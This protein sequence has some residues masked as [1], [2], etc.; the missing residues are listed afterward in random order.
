MKKIVK[1]FCRRGVTA[2]GI[3]P[4]ILAVLYLIL[5]KNGAITTLTVNEV[6]IG[7][8]SLSAL[9]FIAG[10]V[11]VIYQIE[12]LPLMRAISIHGIVLYLSYLTT[13]LLNSWLAWG[14]A[15][16]LVFTV[17]FLVGYLAVWV[18]IYAVTKRNTA[19]VNAMLSQ[20]RQELK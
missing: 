7:I 3:G 11:N 20:N 9:A 2:C 19:Q 1:E 12:T 16:I 4:I 6:C 5:Q 13:Y 8:F 17:I 14:T 15:P 10:G 18:V